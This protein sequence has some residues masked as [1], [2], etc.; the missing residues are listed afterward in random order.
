MSEDKPT[1]TFV[2]PDEWI[3]DRFLSIFCNSAEQAVLECLEDDD[4]NCG[5]DYKRAFAAQG[6]TQEQQDS[7]IVDMILYDD[8]DDEWEEEDEESEADEWEG[9]DED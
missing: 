5:F 9:E 1:V 2:F 3:R 6:A 4:I 7:P 8:E